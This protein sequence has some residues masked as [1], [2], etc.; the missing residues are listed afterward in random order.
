MDGRHDRHAARGVISPLLANVCLH[1]VYDLWVQQWRSRQARGDVIAIRYAGDTIVGFQ[2]EADAR[3]FLDDLRTRL[4]KFELEL[5]PEKTRLIPFGRYAKAHWPDAET[6]GP[7]TF[8]FLGFTHICAKSPGGK[9]QLKR[10]TMR[11]RM[12]ARARGDQG[13]DAAPP[14]PAHSR[15]GTMAEKRRGGLLRLPRCA[16]KRARYLGIPV[17]CDPDV[18][19]VAPATKS[20]AYRPWE[21][22]NRIIDAGIPLAVIS[23]PWPS[24]RVDVKHPRQKP[25][26]SAAHARI[27]AARAA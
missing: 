1:Y 25:S 18:A 6:G 9:F 23:H 15:T 10:Q 3:R 17:S 19:E 2:H 22:M 20:T 11:K 8:D 7:E 12:R 26:A 24:Q 21:R 16:D 14:A 5:H 27:C 4:A 13:G